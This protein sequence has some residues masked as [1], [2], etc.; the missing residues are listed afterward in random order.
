MLSL[1]AAGALVTAQM[2]QLS[3][4]GKET[5]DFIETKYSMPG[6]LYGDSVTL[7]EGPKAPAFNWGVGVMLTAL[8]AAAEY[9]PIYK[10]RLRTFADAGRVYW[11]TEGPV[12]GYDVLPAPKP[13]DRYYDDNAWMVMGLVET[14]EVLGDKKYLGWA[15]ET[16]K[17]VFSGEDL[18]LGGGIYWR[19]SD[20][21][22]KYTCSNAPAAA[23]ALAVYHQT[24]NSRQLRDAIRIYSWTKKHLQDPEDH[25]FYDGLNLKGE[26]GKT[27]WSYNTA[28]M[29]R[30]AADL[31]TCTKNPQYLTDV[32]QMQTASSK[33]WL[34]NGKLAD[35]GRFAHLLMESWIYQRKFAPVPNPTQAASDARA[36]V[37]PLTFLHESGRNSAGFYGKRFDQ[38]PEEG[39]K[40]SE[41]I[42]QASA[43]RA[44][45]KAALY[46][47]SIK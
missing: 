42:D 38:A 3:D 28:L 30:S 13:I 20:K 11:N 2:T 47:R 36:F 7:T 37:E 12:A 22:G 15:E 6:G 9:D 18:K 44:Y 43:A 10:E 16:L 41:L 45:F 21:P 23:A 19:E 14:Y 17:Y 33:K 1:L 39:N 5:L 29:I 25:L 27:K 31:Y 8:S 4:Y 24:K 40:E 32:K 26:I 34:V 35:E 46:Y